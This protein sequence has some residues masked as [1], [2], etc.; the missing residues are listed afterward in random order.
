MFGRQK[1]LKK[2][3]VNSEIRKKDAFFSFD[4]PSYKQFRIAKNRNRILIFTQLFP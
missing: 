4:L 1:K 2:E 3:K